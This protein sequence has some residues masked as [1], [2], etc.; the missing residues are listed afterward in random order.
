MKHVFLVAS[1]LTFNIANKVVEI[2][3]ISSTDCILLLT[4]DYKI[5]VKYESRFPNQIHTSYNVSPNQGRIF[6]GI[7]IF[8][9]KKNIKCFD[10]LVDSYIKGEDFVWY[11]SVCSNDI[12]SLMVTKKNC[13]G[14]YIMEDGLISYRKN[15]PPT[16]SG[17]SFLVYRFI[18]K[19]FFYRIYAVK[20]H[21]IEDDSPKFLGCIATSDKCFPLQK[22]RLRNIGLPFEDVELDKTPE[23][24]LSID[25]LFLVIDEQATRRVFEKLAK[26]IQSKGYRSI[27]YKFHPRFNASS[28]SALKQMYLEML[29]QYF[30]I[31]MIE[32]PAYIVVEGVL[33][34][35]RCDFF[36]YNS[37]IAIYGNTAGARCYTYIP[38]IKTYTDA[39]SADPMIFEVCIPIEES[40]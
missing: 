7:N 35:Y 14:Y 3:G 38:L 18:L 19:P 20:N 8:K 2:D 24:V 32:L 5:P 25:P 30:T 39:Y 36:T 13:K 10:K 28:N 22:D 29:N 9:T 23:A 26:Y 17:V 16:F 27:A 12:C 34:K 31:E 11:T 1:N 4:R 40:I 15:I 33:K 21:F 37:S 6:A